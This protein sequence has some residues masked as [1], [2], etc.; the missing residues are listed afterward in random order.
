MV[1]SDR[2]DVKPSEQRGGT[3]PDET[4]AREKGSWAVQRIKESCRPSWAARTRRRSCWVRTPSWAA[5]SWGERPGQMNQ[6]PTAGSIRSAAITL[7]QLKTAAR[8]W[9]QALS[10]TSRTPW[11]RGWRKRKSP[12]ARDAVRASPKGAAE[13]MGRRSPSIRQGTGLTW[14]WAAAVWRGAPGGS[15]DRRGGVRRGACAS[16]AP[17]G[18][19][20]QT[21]AGRAGRRLG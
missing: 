14:R 10:L 2:E 1:E 12:P 7:M 19:A 3:T 20:R 11:R 9:R 4:E 5:L 15:G 16:S 13:L 21:R 8:S 6:Q 17:F 18:A